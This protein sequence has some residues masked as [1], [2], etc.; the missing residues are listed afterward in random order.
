M[1]KFLN[2]LKCRIGSKKQEKIKPKIV[3]RLVYYFLGKVNLIS[4]IKLFLVLNNRSYYI[5]HLHV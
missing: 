2:S 4:I 1:D 5:C 3:T